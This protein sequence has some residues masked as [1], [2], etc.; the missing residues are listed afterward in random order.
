MN[1]PCPM[2]LAFVVTLV[3][4]AA[5]LAAVP[6]PAPAAVDTSERPR[7]RERLQEEGDP[8]R[9]VI[10]FDHYASVLNLTSRVE[11]LVA[12]HAQSPVFAAA[13]LA[14]DT[15]ARAPAG[16]FGLAGES[17]RTQGG[18]SGALQLP[19]DFVPII[20]LRDCKAAAADLVRVDAGI[21]RVFPNSWL[22]HQLQAF[23]GP[24]STKRKAN[25]DVWDDPFQSTS[26]C[27]G[28]A[29]HQ[30]MCPTLSGGRQ[31]LMRGAA[32]GHTLQHAYNLKSIWAAGTRGQGVR[33]AVL[34]SGMDCKGMRKRFQHLATCTDWTMEGTVADGVGHGTFVA[35]MLAGSFASCG[36]IAPDI[37]LHVRYCSCPFFCSPDF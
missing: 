5:T 18:A 37:E 32:R 36:G 14:V 3:T 8:I 20:C 17:S 25:G 9:L 12:S 21:K 11:Q 24:A 28:S 10:Q 31:M 7:P 27:N 6:S 22:R 2:R 19:T 34:D 29:K 13:G 1:Q 16:A 15:S 26:D 33:V 30:A 35:G 4:L 23:D